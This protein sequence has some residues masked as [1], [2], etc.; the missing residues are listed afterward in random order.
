MEVDGSNEDSQDECEPVY[1]NPVVQRPLEEVSTGVT[2]ADDAPSL[3]MR[4]FSMRGSH[5]QRHRWG[6]TSRHI[7]GEYH[8]VAKCS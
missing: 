7:Q 2:S 4:I 3:I 8:R 6:T 5:P 1:N